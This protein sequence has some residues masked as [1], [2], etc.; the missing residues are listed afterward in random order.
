MTTLAIRHQQSV[1][2]LGT[3]TGRKYHTLLLPT[4]I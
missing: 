3:P 2:L 1:F 4:H